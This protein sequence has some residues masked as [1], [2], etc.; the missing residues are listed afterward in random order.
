MSDPLID[1]K[2]NLLK[3]RSSQVLLAGG[4]LSALGYGAWRAGRTRFSSKVSGQI[5]LPGLSQPVEVWRDQW[6][7][8]HLYAANL[9]DL[10]LAQG[11]VQ[12]QDRFWQMELQRR[13]AAGRL[14]E[15]FGELA[16][17]AD[18]L[19]RRLE[20]FHEAENQYQWLLQ[21]EDSGPLERFAEGVNAFLA[22]K[23]LPLEFSLLRYEPEP[24]LPTDS[25]GWANVMALGQ[26]NNFFT[27]L[28]RAEIVRAVGPEMAARLEPWPSPGQ[29]LIVPPTGDYA[30]LDFAPLLAE[31]GKLAGWLGILRAGTGSNN[32][33]VDGTKST[34]GKPLLANDPHI[35]TQLPAIFYAIHLSAPDFEVAGASLPGLPGVMLGHNRQIAWGVTNT[36]GNNQDAFIE[37]LDPA[38]P[39]RY[40]HQDQ[41]HEFE[42]HFEE[43]RVKGRPTFRQEQFKSLH[44]PIISEFSASGTL[45]TGGGTVQGEPV[46]LAWSLYRKS[47]SLEG[48]LQLNQ[49]TDWPSFRAALEKWY[50]PSFNFVYADTA[51]NIGYQYAGLM[52]LRKKGLGLLPSPGHTGEYDWEGFIPF[53]E[54]PSLYNPPAHFLYSA[55]NKVTPDD[56]PYQLGSDYANGVRAERI[57]QILTAQ[58]KFSAADFEKMFS[59]VVCLTGLRLARLV[60]KLDEGVEGLESRARRLLV[61]WDGNLTADSV[62]GCLYE[63]TMNKLLRQVL[64][65]QLGKTA[66]DHYLGVAEGFVPLTAL[67]SLA[68]PHLLGFAERDDTSL[69]PPDQTWDTA[70][71][72][73]F[74]SAVSW[75]RHTFG[76]DLNQWEWGKL[77]QIN[78]NHFLG[79]RPPLDRVFNRG[80]FAVGGDSD[81]IFQTAYAFKENQYIANGGTP[82]WRMIADLSDWD[83]CLMSVMSGQSGSPF[84]PHYADMLEPW[85][86]GQLHPLPFSREAVEKNAAGKLTLQPVRPAK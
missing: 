49:A 15:I 4:A 32:W 29:P 16:V 26:S 86:N 59:D 37:Q 73:A 64:E 21:H 1:E 58:A 83:K 68:G 69:L 78:F 43:I 48:L 17:P 18:R 81:T 20:L 28:A 85:F 7:V 45:A 50:C 33:V 67:Y 30:G 54:L 53:E 31:Y 11:F 80:P 75:L 70:L 51:G 60:A 84:S 8:A 62:A 56:Y 23:K 14:A 55:N 5:N 25:L 57:R 82:A 38:N 44:G 40:R 35:S 19:L 2:K 79:A 27:E 3:T 22:L 52:P 39:R 12:A 47:F 65:P 34:T 71:K 9:P 41:W 74:S 13:M 24:W 77:H 42:T 63:V 72:L 6:G 10:F 61:E 66:T 46:A 76:E 36:M